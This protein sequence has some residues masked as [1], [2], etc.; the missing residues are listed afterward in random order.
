MHGTPHRILDEEPVRERRVVMRARGAD[1]KEL[2]PASDQN[3]GLL[4]DASADDRAVTDILN[5]IAIAE[6][7]RIGPLHA[8]RVSKIRRWCLASRKNLS[9]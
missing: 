7:R 9:S 6:I 5:R 3:D 4:T 2:L 1:G 8:L